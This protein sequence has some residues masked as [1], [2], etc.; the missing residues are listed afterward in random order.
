MWSYN[1]PLWFDP[2]VEM[3]PSCM[4]YNIPEELVE[5]RQKNEEY[6]KE[7]AEL[8]EEIDQLRNEVMK[9]KDS[10]RAARKDAYEANYALD[11][12]LR[13]ETPSFEVQVPQKT[14][15]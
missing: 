1:E 4:E 5:A 13:G 11:Q 3:C 7:V 14:W 9:T 15:Y 6:R 10:L 2:E 12:V 8:R